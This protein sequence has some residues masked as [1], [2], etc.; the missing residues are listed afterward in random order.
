MRR[1]LHGAAERHTALKL[2]RNALGCKRR[3]EFWFAHLDDVQI[4]FRGRELR[5]LAA[6]LLNVG[7]LLADQN[8]GTRCVHRHPALLMGAFNHDLRDAC[9][10]PL[11]QDKLADAEILVQELAVLSLARIPAAIPRPVNSEPESDWVDF[12]PH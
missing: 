5:E 9:L 2:L 10:P 6:Q 8:A 3:I 4:H 11:L 12:L 7:A 1:A